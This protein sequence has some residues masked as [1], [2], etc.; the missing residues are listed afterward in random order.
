MAPM[1]PFMRWASAIIRL[2]IK[3]NGIEIR[4]Q[5]KID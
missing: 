5:P 2:I 4:M 3:Q 1:L